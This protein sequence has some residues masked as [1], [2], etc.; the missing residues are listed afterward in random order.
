MRKFLTSFLLAFL[1]VFFIAA[2][3]YAN[4]NV[5]PALVTR[6][7]DGDTLELAGGE[8]VRLI[9]V[10]APEIGEPGAAQATA[11]VRQK[12]EGRTVWLEADGNDRDRFGRLRR[13]VWLQLPANT[14]DEQHI[15]RYQLNALLLINGH[16]EVLA[17]GS[18]RNEALFRQ[19]ASE[20][21]AGHINIAD[22]EGGILPFI[23]NVNS[24]IFH[25]ST[26]RSLPAPQ[27]QVSFP[28][29]QAALDAGHRPCRICSP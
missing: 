9:G 7:I 10:D 4:T 14:Q 29:R 12:T 11:F 21:N 3:V 6:V 1:A 17:I 20:A 13:Y 22:A 19:I 16:A 26:C 25:R 8:R 2:P 5:T 18:P 27:N 28:T 24:Q 15:R 23:G